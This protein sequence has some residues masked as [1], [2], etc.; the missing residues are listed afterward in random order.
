MSQMVKKD[1]QVDKV[2]KNFY[3]TVLILIA[4]LTV[5]YVYTRPLKVVEVTEGNVLVLDNGSKI[6][7]MGVSTGVQA[8]PLH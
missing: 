5:T 6:R 4:V 2:K 8:G 3:V 1:I 7:L